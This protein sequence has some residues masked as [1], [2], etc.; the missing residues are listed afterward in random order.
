MSFSRSVKTSGS[1]IAPDFAH[2]HQS[3]SK[4]VPTLEKPSP[5]SV[6]P[7]GPAVSWLAL[8]DG[9]AAC[10][11]KRTN[12]MGCIGHAFQTL[13]AS[14][15]LNFDVGA[16]S[17]QKFLAPPLSGVGQSKTAPGRSRAEAMRVQSLE[18]GMATSGIICSI[19]IRAK[20]IK[21]ELQHVSRISKCCQ[22][23]RKC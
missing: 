2:F 12:R 6:S 20:H 7:G 4:M 18:R 11:K 13:L 8:C 10:P 19:L 15:G 5:L 3:M 9:V 22:H 17:A 23:F 21:T 14:V 1:L 16:R